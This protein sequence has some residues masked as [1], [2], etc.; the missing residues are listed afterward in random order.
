[1]VKTKSVKEEPK[2]E[3]PKVEQKH[4]CEVCGEQAVVYDVPHWYCYDHHAL[5]TKCWT[6]ER[7]V[8][9]WNER[10]LKKP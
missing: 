4:V 1:M 8:K 2:K 5:W 10:E 7:M 9:A 6:H 3:V